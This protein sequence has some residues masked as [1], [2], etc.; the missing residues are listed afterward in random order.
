MIDLSEKLEVARTR[1]RELE[2]DRREAFDRIERL[3]LTLEDLRTSKF[4]V[5]AI[6]MR[7]PGLDYALQILH[8]YQTPSGQVIIVAPLPFE[9]NP[10]VDDADKT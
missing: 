4:M 10:R 8:M 3:T 7:Y 6:H 1:I 9:A 2:N 5:G